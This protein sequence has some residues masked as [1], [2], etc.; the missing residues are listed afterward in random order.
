MNKANL[1]QGQN[2]EDILKR[3]ST[4][5]NLKEALQGSHYVQ[6]KLERILADYF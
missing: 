4:T 1:L 3:V 5:N 2:P 6:V